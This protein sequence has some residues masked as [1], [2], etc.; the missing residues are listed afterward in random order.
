MKL[1]YAKVNGTVY[2][3]RDAWA[4]SEVDR[5]QTSPPLANCKDIV[6]IKL[7]NQVKI[8]WE[9]PGDLIFQQ[10]TVT[11]QRRTTLVRKKGGIPETI[12]DGVVIVVEN[13]V[14]QYKSSVYVDYLPDDDE[15][16]YKLFP[17]STGGLITNSLQNAFAP[18]QMDWNQ[19]HNIVE[20]GRANLYFSLGQVV[21]SHHDTYGDV[22]WQIVSFD[23]PWTFEDGLQHHSITLLSR[24]TLGSVQFDAAQ[25]QYAI[26]ADSVWM[27]MKY[28][29]YV[30]ANKTLYFVLED[31][32]KFVSSRTW[33]STNGEYRLIYAIDRWKIFTTS[34]NP[35]VYNWQSVATSPSEH[36]YNN[37]TQWTT[38]ATI[39][40]WHKYFTYNGTTYTQF[41]DFTDYQ[42]ITQQDTYYERIPDGSLGGANNRK[43]YGYNRWRDSGVRQWLNSQSAGGTYYIQ[44]HIW[45]NPSNQMATSGFMCG[46]DQVGF[47]D[48]VATVIHQVAV[49]TS[50]SCGGFDT[51]TDRFFL[52]TTTQVGNGGNAGGTVFQ[53]YTTDAQAKRVKYSYSAKTAGQFW[54]TA[55]PNV[56]TSTYVWLIIPAGSLNSFN[57]NNSLGSVPACVII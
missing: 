30:D 25:K 46:F 37:A 24:Y 19:L 53:Y 13:V 40:T 7:G 29:K 21:T 42:P 31:E 32:S 8:T 41:T 22:E 14:N 11:K 17:Q 18:V 49:N 48:N 1:G 56:G 6:A 2:K 57:A 27:S 3:F 34:G 5:K 51:V 10:V 52:P 33:K 38:S 9:D 47:L 20:T 44:P 26:T 45:D 50:D 4:K 35:Q 23:H 54:W 16:Y 55:A 15:Y 28:L 36:P 39:I 43:S 12:S